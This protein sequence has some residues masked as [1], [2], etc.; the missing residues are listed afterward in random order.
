[1]SIFKFSV[2]GEPIAKQR[3]K[4]VNTCGFAHAYTPQKTLDYEHYVAWCF[5]QSYPNATPLTQPLEVE[6]IFSF[7]LN[8]NDYTP[9][10]KLTKNGLK[11]LNGELF[12]TTK[13]DVDNLIKSVLD[14]LNG[15]AYK[16]D[17]QVIK[18][19]AFKTYSEEPKAD[20]YINTLDDKGD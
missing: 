11:K 5:T 8:K 1:M 12:P 3:P 16:D 15:I 13:K 4:V 18:I 6:I 20:I 17:K 2:N 19:K 9:K 14:G 7:G 10:G